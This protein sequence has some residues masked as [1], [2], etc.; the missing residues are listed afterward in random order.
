M[1]TQ[2]NAAMTYLRPIVYDHAST[3]NRSDQITVP[4]AIWS[5]FDREHVGNGPI[6]VV[7]DGHC[8]GRLRPATT[9]DALDADVMR[10]PEWL[11][12]Q[13]SP[14]YD[15]EETWVSIVV[16]APRFVE[17]LVL[18]P[19]CHRDVL[20]LEDPVATLAA[21]IMGDGSGGWGSLTVGA[22]LMLPSGSF[23]VMGLTCPDGEEMSVGCIL[24]R[25]INLDFLPALDY[26]PPRPPTP[27][28]AAPVR[29]DTHSPMFGPSHVMGFVPFSGTGYRLGR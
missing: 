17:K 4:A 2:N 18:Q 13:I 27:I 21:Q 29:L 28:P 23:N 8:M 3:L 19:Q 7:L 22:S 20:A 10:V 11:W 26:V 6:F 9:E 25:D 5:M 15:E 1:P 14:S 24:D 12:H 16:T